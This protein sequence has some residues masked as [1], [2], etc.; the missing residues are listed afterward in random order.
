M[1]DTDQLV[2]SLVNDL[3]PV[4]ASRD[5]LLPV[6]LWFLASVA[7]VV[8]MTELIGPVRPNA[9]EQLQSV[10]RYTLEIAFGIVALA[11][12]AVAA[13]RSAIPGRLTALFGRIALAL[14]AIWGA[15]Y[16]VAVVAPALEPSMLGKRGHCYLETFVYALP[17]LL[18]A[19]WWQRRHY[20]LAPAR[21]ALLAGLVAGGL[22]GLYMQVACMY[23]PLHGLAFHLGPALVV[24]ACSPLLLSAWDRLANRG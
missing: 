18:V 4:A 7:Y 14:A 2:D 15:G 17:P 20:C 21:S 5:L 13:F 23:Q 6:V 3:K 10:P 8:V 12:V 1:R 24:A 22:P 9:L 11:T 16:I 19:L